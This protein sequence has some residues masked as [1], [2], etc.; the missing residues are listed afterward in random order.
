MKRTT[1]ISKQEEN[2]GSKDQPSES[3]PINILSPQEFELLHSLDLIPNELTLKTMDEHRNDVWIQKKADL[4]E[5]DLSNSL[6]KQK[7]TQKQR[8]KMVDW[9]IEVMY[10]QKSQQAAFFKAAAILD[11]YHKSTKRYPYACFNFFH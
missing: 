11:L 8:A 2:G 5:F 7:V 3:F 1:E 4:N 10:K 6:R 9:M